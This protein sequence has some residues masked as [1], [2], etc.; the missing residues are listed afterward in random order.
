LPI[1]GGNPYHYVIVTV[2]GD[3][4]DVEVIGVDWGKGFA[5][6]AS[7][8]ASLSDRPPPP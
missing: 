1:A 4:L 7:A 8:S 2:A 3:Q 6:Y 5:P